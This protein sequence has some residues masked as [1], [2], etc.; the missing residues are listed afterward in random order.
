QQGVDAKSIAA[1]RT[2][3]DAG[4]PD[5]PFWSPRWFATSGGDVLT[6]L[7]QQ[8]D[9]L[10]QR[11]VQSARA[12]AA[13]SVITATTYAAQYAAW[14]P[15]NA[16]AVIQSWPARLANAQSMTPL[17]YT[18]LA[19]S[20][21]S[22]FES[23]QATAESARQSAEITSQ[24]NQYGGPDALLSQASTLSSRAHAD[25]LDASTVDAL[26][27]Q[28]R[29][30]LAQS[31]PPEATASVAQRLF[32][33]MNSLQELIAAN[34]QVASGLRPLLWSTD[35]AAA[36][37]T[38]NAPSL[39][40]QYNALN[41]AF[42]NAST[43]AQVTAV[44]SQIATLQSQVQ[45]ELDANQCGHHVGSGR[46]ITVSLSLQEALFYQ[47][48]CVVR[49]TPV[50]TGRAYLRT[51]PGNYSV[52]LRQSP[53]LMHSS[54][55]PG[56]PFWYP[57]TEVNWVLE[58]Q[59]GGYFLHDAS[60]ESPSAFGPGSED[61]SAASHGC[62]HIPTDTMRWLYDWASVGTPVTITS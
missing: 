54:W 42:Q 30:D 57:D 44:K 13:G 8:T 2:E 59:V 19:K 56:S 32:L 37:G 24:I 48:G 36:E 52:F 55:P 47:D 46:V 22:T 6:H 40:S 18:K 27:P 21:Q 12:F 35:Q 1:L 10:W 51:P 33:A 60:W 41:T 53:W 61:T 20:W 58:F 5:Q 34:D 23:F 28:L 45:S 4:A 26:I 49:G 38:P 7:Q 39:L 29:T 25:N 9:A 17:Q 11:S 3:L 50:T 31:P 62:I 14:M 15:K 43:S 16:I